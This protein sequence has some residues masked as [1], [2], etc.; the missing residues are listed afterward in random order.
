MLPVS[1]L[2]DGNKTFGG[3]VLQVGPKAGTFVMQGGASKRTPRPTIIY[4]RA[5][6][7]TGAPRPGR[8]VRVGEQVR[9]LASPAKDGTF[10][11]ISIEIPQ[12]GRGPRAAGMSGTR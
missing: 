4:D 7:W 11:A 3:Q 9:V 1:L 5:T 6:H 8:K 10:R 2:A 12:P